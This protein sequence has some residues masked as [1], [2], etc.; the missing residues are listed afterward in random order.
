MQM[1]GRKKVSSQKVLTSNKPDPEAS[2][3]SKTRMS[4]FEEL[5]EEENEFAGAPSN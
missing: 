1:N 2:K 5:N 4:Q 3:H